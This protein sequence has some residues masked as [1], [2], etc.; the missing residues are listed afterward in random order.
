MLSTL[1]AVEVR[2]VWVTPWEL[3]SP[4]KIDRIINDCVENHINEIIA[5]IR[6]R[7]DALYI[8][9]KSNNRFTNEEPRSYLL[10]NTS[11]DPLDYIIKKAKAHSIK[12]QAWGTVF[13]ITPSNTDRLNQDHLWFRHRDWITWNSENKE[14]TTNT[15]EGAYLDPSIPQVRDYLANVFADIALNYDVDGIHLDYIRY[16]D[17]RFGFHPHAISEFNKEQKKNPKLTWEQWKEKQVTETV[18][19]IS[20]R[21][22]SVKPYITLSAAVKPEPESAVK[23]FGQNWVNWLD[24][25]LIDQVYLMAYQTKDDS[26]NA[27]MDKLPEK[28]RSKII[29]GLRAWT[30]GKSY[31]AYLLRNKMMTVINHKMKGISFFSYSGIISESYFSTINPLLRGFTNDFDL[32]SSF[33]GNTIYGRVLGLD[34][35]PISGAK[36]THE[37]TQQISYSDY[38]GDFVVYQVG[39]KEHN[40]MI[41]YFD[42]KKS[43][44]ADIRKD[45]LFNQKNIFKLNTFPAQS[46]SLSL[47]AF[48]DHQNIFLS[49]KCNEKKV[50]SLY[51]KKVFSPDHKIDPDFI[52][53]KL[54]SEN[55]LFYVDKNLEPFA[56]YEYKLIDNQMMTQGFT[57]IGLDFTAHPIEFDITKLNQ[58]G[59]KFQITLN[60]LDTLMVNWSILDVYEKPLFYGVNHSNTDVIKWNGLTIDGENPENSFFIFEY[61]VKNPEEKSSTKKWYRK[62]FY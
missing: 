55:D 29:V 50:F 48:S 31:P 26:F 45:E 16:P 39:E 44:K 3:N 24:Q 41:E 33:Q 5:E 15:L 22:R 34:N 46:L 8:P 61:Y 6:Y 56:L 27:M 30:D 59:D 20:V 13:V 17:H 43:F 54:L 57:R 52:F 9:N 23:Y 36:I 38:N 40:I 58:E 21:V 60:S 47:N 7:G 18:K 2:S 11:F 14:M 32:S 12:V 4:E 53:I 62:Y 25:N 37:N 35:K 28:Y 10:A 1:S 42:Q 19:A 49:W 51:R